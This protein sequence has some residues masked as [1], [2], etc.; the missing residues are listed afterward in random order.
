MLRPAVCALLLLAGC[1]SAPPPD[2]PRTVAAVDLERYAGIWHEVARFPNRFQDGSGVSCADTTATYSARKDGR[3]G[4]VN[5]CRNAAVA[6]APERVAD[7]RA[8]AVDGSNGA[9]LRVS[10]FWPFH[11]DYWVLGL[12]PDYRWAVV[13]APRRDYLWILSRTPA[14]APDDWDAALAVARREGFETAK[15][16]RTQRLG[17]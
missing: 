17:G 12:S 6:G 7:G 8:Y 10:F 14:M 5:R 9:R 2:A 3:I 15:L 4:V 16:R 1:A 11:G 13:G